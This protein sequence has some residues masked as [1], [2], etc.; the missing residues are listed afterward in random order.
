MITNGKTSVIDSDFRAGAI[1]YSLTNLLLFS[2]AV[3][4]TVVYGKLVAKNNKLDGVNV[5]AMSIISGIVSVLAGGLFIYSIYK[6]I[7]VREKRDKIESDLRQS[8][9]QV[10]NEPIDIEQ[11]QIQKMR[12]INKVTSKEPSPFSG[13]NKGFTER[14]KPLSNRGIF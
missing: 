13:L 14:V 7:I 6:L 9:P 5:L 11:P 10:S 2:F 8:V 4:N 1:F 12:D 3:T